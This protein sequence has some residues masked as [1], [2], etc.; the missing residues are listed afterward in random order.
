MLALDFPDVGFSTRK[1]N[2]GEVIL[3]IPPSLCKASH[4]K[5][6]NTDNKKNQPTT[7]YVQKKKKTF[8]Q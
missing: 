2:T 4:Y 5:V 7:S 6:T 3:Q 8:K 1:Q